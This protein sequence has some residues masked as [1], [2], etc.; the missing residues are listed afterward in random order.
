M[1]DQKGQ[2]MDLMEEEKSILIILDTCRYDYFKEL[3]TING[4]LQ[5]AKSSGS[6]TMEWLTKTWTGYYNAAYVSANPYIALRWRSLSG[7]LG[8]EHFKHVEEVWKWGFKQIVVGL[9]DESNDSISLETIPAPEVVKGVEMVIEKGFTKIVAHFMQPHSP[10]IGKTKCI[11]P[12]TLRQMDLLRQAYR[13]NLIYV[14]EEGVKPLLEHTDFEIVITADH[15]E[16]LGEGGKL[17]HEDGVDTPEL[18]EVPWLEVG[19]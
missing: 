3:N 2:I 9:V 11:M 7:W 4:R 1:I 16:L 10:Y 12:K 8:S 14:L 15:G 5:K 18:R 13:D 17:E 19:K 6:A